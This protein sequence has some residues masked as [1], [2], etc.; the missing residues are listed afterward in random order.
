MQKL[1]EIGRSGDEVREELQRRKATDAGQARDRNFTNVFVG[2]QEAARLA[3]EAYNLYLW[4]NA[5]DPTAYPGIPKFERE[6]TAIAASHLRGGEGVVGSFTSGGTESL[7]L[8]VKAARDYARSERGITHPRVV[9]PLTGHPAVVKAGHF[10]D[11]EIV[12]TPID[13]V[14]MQADPAAMA[15]AVDENTILLLASAP[16]YSFGVIDPIEEI[17]AIAL[18]RGMPFHVDACIGGWLLPF[19]RDLGADVPAFDFTVE[20]VTSISVDLHKYALCAKGASCVLYRDAELRRY[21]Y[22]AFADW[23]GYALL[24]STV[25]STKPGGPVAAAWAVLQHIGRDGYLEIAGRILDATRL[26]VDEVGE[27][28]GARVIGEPA[29]SL[30]AVATDQDVFAVSD[31]MATRGWR[32]F[33]Q[34]SYG[35]FPRTLHVTVLPHNTE[36]VAAWGADLKASI[37]EVALAP[38]SNELDGVMAAI[39]S[40]DL[41]NLSFDQL[42]KLLDMAGV[43]ALTSENGGDDE[44]PPAMAEINNLLDSLPRDVCAKVLVLFLDRLTRPA[45]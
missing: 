41:A 12:R 34:F 20:G 43:G 42:D 22:F 33:P 6:V 37:E 31:A 19:F 15:E 17:A 9:M 1:P 29:A 8:A 14:T 25:Q 38:A 2:S 4:E 18:D 3:E 10:L 11:V 26:I 5:L 21:Q 30:V 32:H 35:D 23:P 16:G 7:M 44:G 28:D 24:N 36:E 13:P 27:I 39:G 45:S 40:L